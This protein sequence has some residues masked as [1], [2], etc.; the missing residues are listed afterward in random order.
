MAVVVVEE[1]DSCVKQLRDFS[2]QPA[3]VLRSI[4]HVKEA[5]AGSRVGSPPSPSHMSEPWKEPGLG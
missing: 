2:L 5:M 3:R 4:V 1:K